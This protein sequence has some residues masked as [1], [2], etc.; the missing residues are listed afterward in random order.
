MSDTSSSTQCLTFG[1]V[2]ENIQDIHHWDIIPFDIIGLCH[3]YYTVPVN[4]FLFSGNQ[5]G[6]NINLNGM[7]CVNVNER[8]KRHFKV[9]NPQIC[10]EIVDENKKKLEQE[11]EAKKK[12]EEEDEILYWDSDEEDEEEQEQKNDEKKDDDRNPL[13]AT[14]NE[15]WNTIKSGYCYTSKIDLPSFVMNKYIELKQFKNDWKNSNLCA[16][17]KCG[18]RNATFNRITNVS[19]VI[20]K[21][22]DL[23]W[24]KSK[25]IINAY[26]ISLPPTPIAATVEC[27]YSN[28]YGLFNIYDGTRDIYRLP[29]GQFGINVDDETDNNN[30]LESKWKWLKMSNMKHYHYKGSLCIINNSD[31]RYSERLFICGGYNDNKCELLDIHNNQYVQISNL[32]YKVSQAG[33]KYDYKKS[34]IYIGGG[35]RAYSRHKDA[36]VLASYYDVFKDK[37]MKLPNT[38]FEHAHHP[39][40]YINDDEP[41][42]LF[43]A[44]GDQ[45]NLGPT[46][47]LDIRNNKG[48]WKVVQD[49]YQLNKYFDLH[50]D[51]LIK[52]LCA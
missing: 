12:E 42:L 4:I 35:S 44:G 47:Y 18:G 32:L 10:Q 52:R 34:R 1:F 37:W 36:S 46:E 14:L 17:F 13:D 20:F 31:N 7:L 27:I 48:K 28:H 16:I 3:A 41:N 8:K 22:N 40:V 38:V 2:R 23:N 43:I 39:I 51:A 26:N 29:F 24:N 15:D 45:H 50:H 6:K 19:A 30:N 25:D 21:A 5:F 11:K 33:I 49:D 9:Y